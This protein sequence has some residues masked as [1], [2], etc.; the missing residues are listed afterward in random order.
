MLELSEFVEPRGEPVRPR[1]NDP[2]ATH[3]A[4]RVGDVAAVHAR[5]AAAG[6]ETRTEPIEITDPGPWQGARAFY[7]TDPDGVTIELIQPPPGRG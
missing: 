7:A 1:A 2:G 5:L 4:L 6:V 3:I